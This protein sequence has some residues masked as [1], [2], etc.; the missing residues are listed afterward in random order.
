MKTIFSFLKNIY[1]CVIGLVR[2]TKRFPTGSVFKRVLLRHIHKVNK[3]RL[4]INGSSFACPTVAEDMMLF[5]LS[6]VGLQ[7]MLDTCQENTTED[8]YRYNAT[9]YRVI[10][11]NEP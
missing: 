8:R 7:S 11:Y 4:K 3:Y 9:K 6:P 10:F 2:N 5:S 1:R